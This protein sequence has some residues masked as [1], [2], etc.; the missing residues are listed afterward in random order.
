M[1]VDHSWARSAQAYLE[2]YTELVA[3]AAP[4]P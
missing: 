1:T 4:S 3:G 2:L